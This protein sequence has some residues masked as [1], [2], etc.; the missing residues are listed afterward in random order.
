[1]ATSLADQPNI[2]LSS[3]AWNPMSPHLELIFQKRPRVKL[4]WEPHQELVSRARDP[5]GLR[6]GVATKRSACGV[7]NYVWRKYYQKVWHHILGIMLTT[8]SRRSEKQV[9]DFFLGCVCWW[10]SQESIWQGSWIPAQ[11]EKLGSREDSKGSLPCH[12]IM[13]G[14]DGWKWEN[15]PACTLFDQFIN[16][17]NWGWI[18]CKRSMLRS[19]MYPL[20]YGHWSS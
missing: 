14:H 2:N 9:D 11:H 4:C 18:W 10:Y 7:K 16:G 13:T 17:L 8:N 6:P 3:M 1:M 19:R 15:S 5:R 20:Q 12:E